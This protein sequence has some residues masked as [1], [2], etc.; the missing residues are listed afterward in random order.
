MSVEEVLAAPGVPVSQSLGGVAEQRRREPVE[1][2]PLRL[3]ALPADV[4][5]QSLAAARRAP[6]LLLLP[7]RTGHA[8]RDGVGRRLGRGGGRRRRPGA[9][10]QVADEAGAGADRRRRRRRRRRREVGS[11]TIGTAVVRRILAAT[12]HARSSNS[13]FTSHELILITLPPPPP[14]HNSR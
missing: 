5:D 12:P 3:E 10:L 13:T 4:D 7:R 2:A 1:R 6:V 8:Q 14:P 11:A 9:G